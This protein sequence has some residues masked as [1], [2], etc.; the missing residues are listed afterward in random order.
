MQSTFLYVG[1]TQFYNIVLTA[2]I[3]FLPEGTYAIFKYVQNLAN[4]VKGLFIQPFMTVFFTEYSLLLQNSKSVIKEFRKYMAGIIN[5]NVVVIIGTILVGD[6]IIDLLWGSKKFDIY[7]V[8][9]SYLFLIFNISAILLSS[10]GAIYRKMAVAHGEGKKL[11]LFWVIAQLLSAGFSYFLI[12]YFKIDGLLF[13]IPVNAFLMGITSY[14]VY[15]QTNN[16]IRYN[17]VSFNNLIAIVLM[18]VAITVKYWSGFY[19]Q[20]DDNLLAISILGIFTLI[21]SLFPLINT[22]KLF[23][24]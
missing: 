24:N 14:F 12:R 11:Y 16:A 17:F 5:I 7:D 19:F 1:A 21:L 20:Y 22:Y 18:A 23:N 13:V 9:L 3:S 2:S 10:L 15:K 6:F 4:K 8:K